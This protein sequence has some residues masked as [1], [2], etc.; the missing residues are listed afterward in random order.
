MTVLAVKG[1]NYKKIVAGLVTA[2]IIVCLIIVGIIVKGVSDRKADETTFPETTVSEE[3]TDVNLILED[4]T[5]EATTEENVPEIENYDKNILSIDEAVT[6]PDT[7]TKAPS[8]TKPQTTVKEENPK[9]VTTQKA[10]TTEE[11]S[12]ASD[13]DSVKEYS[14]GKSGHHCESKETHSFIVSLEKKGCSLCGSHS[15]KSFYAIDEWGNSCYDISKCPKYSEQKDPNKYCD[16]C[17]KKIGDGSKGTCVRFTVDT[18]CPD[19]GKTVKARTCHT[20]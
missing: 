2:I 9:P 4:I 12:P 20:H 6:E 3:T 11:G 8:T 19:C 13:N 5:D 14:C 15:C 10:P 16:E 1:D 17:T 7:T 18:K